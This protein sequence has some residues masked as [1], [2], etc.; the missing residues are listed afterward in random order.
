MLKQYLRNAEIAVKLGMYR[1]AQTELAFAMSAA[2]KTDNYKVAGLAFKA[3]G[4][5][6]LAC[7]QRVRMS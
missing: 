2:R 6:T 3:I 4:Q 5:L 1:Q 7:K